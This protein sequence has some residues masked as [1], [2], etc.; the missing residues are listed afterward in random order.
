[1]AI[2]ENVMKEA[3]TEIKVWKLNIED[4]L[5]IKDIENVYMNSLLVRRVYSTIL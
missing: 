2:D 1:M 3:M 4:T 5:I